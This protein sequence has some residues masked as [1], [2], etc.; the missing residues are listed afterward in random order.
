MIKW[1]HYNDIVIIMIDMIN[2]IIMI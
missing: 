2:M 1:L